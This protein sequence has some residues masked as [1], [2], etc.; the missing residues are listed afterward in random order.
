MELEE[1]VSYKKPIVII[2]IS[3]ALRILLDHDIEKEF[4]ENGSQILFKTIATMKKVAL[5]DPK[6]L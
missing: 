3:L 5:F 2:C 6:I 1:K 4:K